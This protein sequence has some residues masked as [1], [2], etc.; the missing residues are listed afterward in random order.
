M[1]SRAGKGTPERGLVAAVAAPG[2]AEGLG[3]RV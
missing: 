2:D 1:R 3:F